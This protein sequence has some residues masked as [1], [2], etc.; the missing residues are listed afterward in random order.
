MTQR[1][2]PGLLPLSS[3][4][5]PEPMFP[6]SHMAQAGGWFF[7]DFTIYFMWQAGSGVSFRGLQSRLDSEY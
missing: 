1:P 5:P 3:V 4:L 6:L 2:E 7:L